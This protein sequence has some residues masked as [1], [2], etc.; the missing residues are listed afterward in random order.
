MITAREMKM[1]CSEK[2]RFKC[3]KNIT[4]EERKLA[5]NQFYELADKMKQ[6]LCINDWESQEPFNRDEEK[7]AIVKIIDK[8]LRKNFSYKFTLPTS[9]GL[10]CVCQTMFLNTLNQYI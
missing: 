4:E 7:I 1:A 10:V 8:S 9:N 3:T 5:F 6:W 2:C